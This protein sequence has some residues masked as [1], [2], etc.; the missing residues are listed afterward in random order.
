[1]YESSFGPVGRTKLIFDQ[2]NKSIITKDLHLINQKFSKNESNVNYA[3][4]LAKR[5]VINHC[6]FHGDATTS[7][8]I[9]ITNILNNLTKYSST[10]INNISLM[11][12]A[13]EVFQSIFQTHATSIQNMFCERNIWFEVPNLIEWVK[14]TILN[15]LYPATN[16]VLAEFLQ[17]LLV[18]YSS[19]YV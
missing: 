11:V 19:R 8:R 13:I 14:S 2:V 5:T 6:T 7:S 16:C 10:N 9:L 12:K 17:S 15:I 4:N 3:Y 1:M 18:K